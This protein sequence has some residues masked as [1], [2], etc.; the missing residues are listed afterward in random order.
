MAEARI[1]VDLFNPGQV[2]ACL[3]F[4]EAAA[5][6][7]DGVEGG[8]DWSDEAA[9]R[10]VLQADGGQDP[11]REVLGFLGEAEVVA[12][13]PR[14]VHF[15]TAKWNLTLRAAAADDPAF[16]FPAPDSPAVLPASLEARDRCIPIEHWGDATRRD[17]A[18]F[19]AGMAGYPGAAL[20][21]D[22]LDLVRSRLPEAAADPFGLA[23]PQSSGFR[24]DWRRDYVAL[25]AGFSVNQHRAIGMQGHPLVELLAV[26]GLQNARPQRLSALDYR[27]AAGGMML[28][29]IYLRAALGAADLP[30]PLRR[31]RSRLGW[32]GQEGQA[33]CILET[34]EER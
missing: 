12:R 9:V 16:P 22:A 25:D 30:V 5:V 34:V 13:A 17:P 3:G 2:F 1:P 8:F 24:L 6:L 19:W 26:I 4:L 10:F 33:R 11:V 18:K 29:P 14:G 32:P 27:Y 28:P 21:R 15:D 23:A 7:L 31:F 20:V